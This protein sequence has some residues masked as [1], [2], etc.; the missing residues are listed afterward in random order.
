MNHP[1]EI[2]REIVMPVQVYPMFETAIRAAAGRGVEEHQV[3]IS[4]LWAG[5]SAVAA[6][7]PNAWIRD[8]KTAEEIRTVTPTNR[9][10]GFPY[11]KYMN[12]NNDVDMA[13][14]LIIC[15]VEKAESLG[16]AQRPLGVRAQRRRLPRAPVHQQPLVVRGDAGD[17]ARWQ[18][19]A[20]ARRRRRSTTSTSSTCTRASRRR[21]SSARRASGWRC[22][23]RRDR[24]LTRTGGLPFAGGPWNNYV[25]HAIATITSD[26]RERPGAN[27]LVWANG[28]YTTK[29]AFGVYSTEPPAAGFRH[30]HPQ[31]EI[32]AM[33]SR[34][35]AEAAE[36]AGTATIEAYTVMHTREGAPETGDRRVPARRRTSGV[37]HVAR[38][39]GSRRRCATGEWVGREVALAADGTLTA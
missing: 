25:M 37:G 1:S 11:P 9:M 22:R 10:I 34:E 5:F 30:A 7:N 19:R 27:G 2:A 23:R 35:L 33:P 3:R 28:G 26:L 32:D 38:R 31:D 4:E 24:Q 15:S 13:A 12:S 18:A 16:I 14:A 29:H 20:R 39:R 21:C 36:A 8:A 17:R 6:D